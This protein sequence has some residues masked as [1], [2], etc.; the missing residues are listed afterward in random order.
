MYYIWSE[1]K[2]TCRDQCERTAI[3]G[4]SKCVD[5]RALSRDSGFSVL[6]SSNVNGSNSLL[7]E[8][9]PNETEIAE[10]P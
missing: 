1:T 10:L 8:S 5:I 7:G 3:L 2:E 4:Q 6:N 9:S